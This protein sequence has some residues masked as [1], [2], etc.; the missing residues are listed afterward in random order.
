MVAFIRSL[1]EVASDLT[2]SSLS[3]GSEPS[4]Q[5]NL[6]DISDHTQTEYDELSEQSAEKTELTIFLIFCGLLLGMFIKLLT[7][8]LGLPYTPFLTL[9]G[10]AIGELDRTFFSHDGTMEGHELQHESITRQAIEGFHAPEPE[11]TFLIFL[12]ALI[13]E[14]AFNSDWYTFKR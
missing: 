6:S 3:D 8:K 14:S 9:A 5:R 2:L 7:K 1:D 13:F 10:V 11:I 4:D 12:P